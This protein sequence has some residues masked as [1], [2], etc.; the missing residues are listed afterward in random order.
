MRIKVT[1]SEA[2][3]VLFRGE[4]VWNDARTAYAC[5]WQLERPRSVRACRRSLARFLL[6]CGGTDFYLSEKE[7]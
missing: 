5:G 2:A 7:P 4:I 3:H 6:M 1:Y